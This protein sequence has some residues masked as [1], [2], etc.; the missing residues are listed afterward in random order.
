MAQY[1]DKTGLGAYHKI[2]KGMVDNLDSEITD[3]KNSQITDIGVTNQEL[4][5]TESTQQLKI[6]E[7]AEAD[8]DLSSNKVLTNKHAKNADTVGSTTTN[9]GSAT[10]PVY[11]A[12]GV[13]TA[14]NATVGGDG[15]AVYLK[16]GVVTSAG[17]FAKLDES[18]KIPT[19]YLPSYV[20]DVFE[21][22]NKAAFPTKGEANKIY[23]AK[24][25]NKTYRWS[26]SNY[27]EISPSIVIGTTEGTAFDGAKGLEVAAAVTALQQNEG[28]FVS[29]EN[30][31]AEVLGTST[32]L[33]KTYP[34]K[35]FIPKGIVM[36]GT[37][38]A[39]G[40]T[41]RG[42]T[43]VTTP[44][45][46]GACQKDVLYLNFDGGSDKSYIHTV[47]L[48][49]PN[50]G[51][52][53]DVNSVTESTTVPA[54]FMGTTYGAIRGDQMVNYVTAKLTNVS[55]LTSTSWTYL[56]T[57]RDNGN[58]VPG[59]QYRITDYECTTTQD[60]TSSAGHQFDI[61]VTADSSRV[62][63]EEARAIQ[64]EGDTYF[65]NSNLKAWKIWYSLDNDTSRFEWANQKG[66]IYRMIDEWGND[67]PYDFK[68]IL[69]NCEINSVT[70]TNC[71]T[72]CSE[73][74]NGVDESVSTS[75]NHAEYGNNIIRSYL[76]NGSRQSINKNIFMNGC[77]NN[78]L[79]YN[80]DSN[81]FNN[82]NS[83]TLGNNCTSNTFGYMCFGNTLG[84]YCTS[85]TFISNC[86]ENILG[87]DCESN[88]FN[89]NVVST[90]L[91]TSC[92]SNTFDILCTGNI[93]GSNCTSNKLNG[94]NEFNVFNSDCSNNTLG[95]VCKY[96]IFD[97]NCTNNTLG[98][99]FINNK[100]DSNAS[101]VTLTNNTTGNEVHYYHIKSGVTGE[102]TC[103]EQRDYET[104]IAKR[105]DGT[106]VEYCEADLISVPLTNNSIYNPV[107]RVN[108]K[109]AANNWTNLGTSDTT[110]AL[111]PSNAQFA[112]AGNTWTLTTDNL[113][114][115]SLSI[116]NNLSSIL[117]QSN[118][119][120][121]LV[122]Y[123]PY[124]GATD[125]EGF[126][127]GLGG[128]DV[129]RTHPMTCKDNGY[130]RIDYKT[131]GGSWYNVQYLKD[132]KQTILSNAYG[133]YVLY[134]V[135]W[136][137]TTKTAQLYINGTLAG[138]ADLSNIF[139][140]Y[141]LSSSNIYYIFGNAI[142]GSSYIEYLH[143]N[144]ALTADEVKNVA[145][146]FA[147][148]YPEYNT[149]NDTTLVSYA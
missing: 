146:A 114:S 15:E 133:K 70:Y 60:D 64:H 113:A 147:Q 27:I 49:A 51:N 10:Q 21:Y 132:G 3:V 37:A 109:S 43:G 101:N 38:A 86:N 145:K 110:L 41:T 79:G 98:N 130:C 62:L 9:V 95:T 24:D 71:Y 14:S 48:G 54:H 120:M 76:P 11:M 126:F 2:I 125:Y 88:T 84:D 29:Y 44:S 136:S 80:C 32:T 100:F 34:D 45:D 66:V 5:A 137:L 68:N 28:N 20:S 117:G 108:A 8:Y 63:N 25:D 77:Y 1:L 102:F 97:S 85:N 127:M 134:T 119:V 36:G 144:K 131:K 23:V 58:L 89:D 118:T 39:S 75:E 135:T 57:L 61:I 92:S 55:N 30:N 90:I 122:K 13:P 116:S 93:F 87:K 53:I 33:A 104:I 111:N 35:L 78:V 73:A 124:N 129:N 81:V 22:D 40:L 17:K 105:S 16:A 123:T 112:I 149:L 31:T 47:V 141:D 143:Y 103:S 65:A 99:R 74:S 67:C 7:F 6:M 138:E 56:K 94:R 18:N 107:V 59:K 42:I 142:N 82:C 19:T 52:A 69:F 83:N 128:S 140:N 91:A 4:T 50:E 139:T 26:G 106:I 96:N 115:S 46:T 148:Q 12:N 72:F 121:A